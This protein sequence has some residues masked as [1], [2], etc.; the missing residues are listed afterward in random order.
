MTDI[1][2]ALGISQLKRL[3]DFVSRRHEIV[4]Y[5]DEALN[6]C[7]VKSQYVPEN[8]YS[9]SHLYIIR[10]MLDSIKKSRLQIFNEM[11]SEGIGVNVHYIP[12]HLQPYYQRMGFKQGD[13]PKAEDYYQQALTLPLYP[14]MTSQQVEQVTQT[15]ITIIQ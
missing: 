9:G 10:L 1:Q 15:L 13:Y 14:D 2:A 11:K 6:D 5:Y 4:S 12:V 8:C 3:D 7:P